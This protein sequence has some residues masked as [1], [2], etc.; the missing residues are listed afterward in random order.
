MQRAVNLGVCSVGS[1]ETA[2]KL[3]QKTADALMRLSHNTDFQQFA[4]WLEIVH[5]TFTQGAIMGVDGQDPAVLRGRAQGISIVK[6][7]MEKASDVAGRIQKI[8]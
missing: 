4:E 5:I 7:E 2:I 6:M 1:K 8:S 3:D